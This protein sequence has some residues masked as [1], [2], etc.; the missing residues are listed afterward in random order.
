MDDAHAMGCAD[1]EQGLLEP[2][3]GVLG[4]HGTAAANDLIEVLAFYKFHHH[5]G[6]A[7]IDKEGVQSGEISVVEAGLGFGFGLETRHQFRVVVQVGGE[8]LDGD[9]AIKARIHGLVDDAHAALTEFLDDA[10]IPN[11]ITYHWQSPPSSPPRW[12]S[13]AGFLRLAL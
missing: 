1:S 13:A 11:L 4:T 9:G 12:F 5:V 8:Q 6:V 2:G 7:L 10:K 3:H